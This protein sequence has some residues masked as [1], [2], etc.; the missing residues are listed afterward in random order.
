[1]KSHPLSDK[2]VIVT[3]ASA[4]LGEQIAIVF[5]KLGATVVIVARRQTRLI[6]LM[7]RIVA[8]GGRGFL[9]RADLTKTNDIKTIT[10]IVNNRL[11]GCDILINNAGVYLGEAPLTKTDLQDWNSVID[12]NLRAPYLLCKALVPGMISQNSGLIINIISATTDL[13]GVGLFRI[14]KIGLEVLTAV[15]AAEL[16]GTAVAALA[17]N[18]GWMKTETC[19]S[20]RS[21]RGAARALAE[22]VQRKPASLNG[23]FVDLKWTG[24]KYRFTNRQAGQGQFGI[25]G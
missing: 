4:G 11:H 2:R 23:R 24:R 9:I 18:P 7:R 25:S 3:G 17:F 10:S 1:M 13:E 5:A 12:T 20:G 22:L 14:S 21:P 6:N 19:L 8:D 15:L 16:E